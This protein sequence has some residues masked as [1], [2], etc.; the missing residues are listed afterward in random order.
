MFPA[1]LVK[2]KTKGDLT[3]ASALIG[4]KTLKKKR[5]G[6]SATW[7]INLSFKRFVF[8]IKRE[9]GFKTGEDRLYYYINSTTGEWTR[10][11]VAL[12]A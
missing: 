3:T 6:K 8:A 10:A 5:L 7:V 11:R 2:G 9:L 4:I 12:E 1:I